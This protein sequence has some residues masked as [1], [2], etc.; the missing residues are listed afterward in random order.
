M[1][2][3]SSRV[4]FS[5]RAFLDI[6]R[7]R[8]VTRQKQTSVNVADATTANRKCRVELATA[9]RALEKLGMSEGVCTHLS[10]MAPAA[11]GDGR[12]MLMI[13]HGLHW[14]T[15]RRNIRFWCTRSV[16]TIMPLLG[17][18]VSRPVNST[19]T[20]STARDDRFTSKFSIYLS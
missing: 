3:Q 1:F 11:N 18:K 6:L 15:V 13:P 9:F 2:V 7:A 19:S 8:L 5:S 14:S 4:G 12:V 20:I 16:E 10:M 17:Y